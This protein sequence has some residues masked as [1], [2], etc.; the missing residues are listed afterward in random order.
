MSN[1]ENNENEPIIIKKGKKQHDAHHGGAWKVAYSDFVTSM[2]ALF[3][4]LWVLAQSPKVKKAVAGYFKDPTSIGVGAGPSAMKGAPLYFQ[5]SALKNLSLQALEKQKFTEM[6]KRILNQLKKNS[7]FKS[8]LNQVNV[9]I[10]KDGLKIEV[11]ESDKDVFFEIGTAKLKKQAEDLL[12]LI[13]KQLSKLN[14][15]IIIEGYTDARPYSGSITG[16][17]NFELSADRAN[18]ARIALMKGGVGSGQIEEIR[19]FADHHLRDKANPFASVNRRISVIVKFS[20]A[21]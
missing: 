9:H 7:E 13:G 12:E 19:G 21:K 8:I 16:Y 2:M 10:T 11:M 20:K 6:G 18:S 4:V 17:S 14:N 15:K 3:I 1:S 5:S